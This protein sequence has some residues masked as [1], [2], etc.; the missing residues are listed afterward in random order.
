MTPAALARAVALE[1]LRACALRELQRRPKTRSVLL[2][3]ARHARADGDGDEVQALVVASPREVPVWPHVCDADADGASLSISGER[4]DRGCDR[5]IAGIEVDPAAFARFCHDRGASAA[6]RTYAERFVPYAIARRRGEG[7]GADVDLEEVGRL[8]RPEEDLVPDEPERERWLDLP[9]ARELYALVL[10]SPA[11]DE[12]RRVLADYLL[13]RGHPRGELIA[14]ALAPDPSAEARARHA[15]LFEAHGR[16]WISPLGAVIPESGR[17]W[18]RGFLARADVY[19]R[20]PVPDEVRGAPAWGTVEAIRFL[21]DDLIDPAMRALRDVGP[22]SAGLAALAAAP[23]PWGIQRLHARLDDDA[24]VDA[25]WGATTLPRLSHLLLEGARRG[26]GL[27]RPRPPWWPHL[28]RL[29]LVLDCDAT[30]ADQEKRRRVYAGI[31][32]WVSVTR[33]SALTCDLGWEVATGPGGRIEISLAGWHEGATPLEL[34]DLVAAL[35]AGAEIAL[36]PS[37]YWVPLAGDA[38]YIADLVRRPV[39]LAPR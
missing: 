17:R 26:W 13:E 6:H 19:V 18:E 1:Q 33:R 9:R 14:L 16:S 15:E 21:R 30:V 4:C 2:A 36:A 37:R 28:E 38:G 22:V 10:A 12:P 3:V 23:K 27:G 32:P 24:A 25:L 31:A 5:G 7:G 34:R 8:W 35:P 11:D 39:E 20:G 29:T